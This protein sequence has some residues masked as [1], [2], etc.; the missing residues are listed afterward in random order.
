M[1]S[2]HGVL[3]PNAAWRREVVPGAGPGVGRQ[4][5]VQPSSTESSEPRRPRLLWAQLLKRCFAVDVLRCAR[6]GARR[7]VLAVVMRPEPII[8]ILTHL[9]LASPQASPRPP[10]EQLSLI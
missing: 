7:E 2:H 6:C 10:P 5:L 9:A 4:L 3:A 8:A 1:D